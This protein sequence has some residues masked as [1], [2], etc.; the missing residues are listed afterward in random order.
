MPILAAPTPQVVWHYPGKVM[1]RGSTGPGVS[2]LQRLL[3]EYG[4]YGLAVDGDF[5]RATLAAVR[6]AQ[7][8]LAVA[9]DGEV[10]PE[11]WGALAKALVKE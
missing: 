10:G 7:K 2:R 3:N 9:V 11:T 4:R 5:G 8:R 1:R 6:D